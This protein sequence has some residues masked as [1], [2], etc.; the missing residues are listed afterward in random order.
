MRYT[1]PISFK[2]VDERVS[3]LL[4]F[5][6]FILALLGY[7]YYPVIFLFLIVDFFLRIVKPIFSPLA[8]VGRFL[9]HK[10]LRVKPK[11]TGAAQKRFTAGI[12]FMFSGMIAVF[13]FYG[14]LFMAKIFLVMFLLAT[15]VAAFGNFCIGC[16]IY[17]LLQTLKTSLTK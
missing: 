11:P 9:L 6:V 14:M 1:C 16:W 15:G 12:G 4:S 2:T 5:F 8:F 3:R 17:T 13:L 7:F 10:V